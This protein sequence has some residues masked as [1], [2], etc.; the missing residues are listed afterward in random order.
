MC[1]CIIYLNYWFYIYITKNNITIV[2]QAGVNQ[3]ARLDTAIAEPVANHVAQ[4]AILCGHGPLGRGEGK[5][6][7][8][9]GN[10]VTDQKSAIASN[11]RHC[12]PKVSIAD[13]P[14]P[15]LR[16]EHGNGV[17]SKGGLANRQTAVTEVVRHEIQSISIA[18][19]PPNLLSGEGQDL[20]GRC[21]GMAGH[22]DDKSGVEKSQTQEHVLGK[23]LGWVGGGED[24]GAGGR[25]GDAQLLA[26]N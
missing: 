8:L 23:L 12:I 17:G 26:V 10:A 3:S 2:I 14:P 20:V 24:G 16:G 15:L 13:G 11:V 25:H 4:V 1:V 7:I 18:D 6:G 5:D 22:G 19:G 21:N 9:R